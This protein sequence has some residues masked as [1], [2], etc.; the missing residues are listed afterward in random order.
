MTTQALKT[1][2]SVIG[3][4]PS[5]TAHLSLALCNDAS[6]VEMM[7]FQIADGSFDL[8][9]KVPA[10]SCCRLNRGKNSFRNEVDG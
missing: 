4:S 1:A 9:T 8:A 2:T 6:E 5:S 7:I 10:T 3:L